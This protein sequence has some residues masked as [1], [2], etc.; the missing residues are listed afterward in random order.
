MLRIGLFVPD[1]TA[2]WRRTLEDGLMV[3]AYAADDALILSLSPSVASWDGHAE[4]RVAASCMFEMATRYAEKV[5]G[6]IIQAGITV[7]LCQTEGT[8]TRTLA[9]YPETRFDYKMLCPGWRAAF[10]VDVA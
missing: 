7:P 5:N 8:H 2:Y 3:T 1:T 9:V 4:K 10:E 6:T